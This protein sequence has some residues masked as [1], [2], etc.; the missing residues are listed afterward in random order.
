MAR[1]NVQGVGV[2]PGV[3]AKSLPLHLA[4]SI[5]FTLENHEFGSTNGDCCHSEPTGGHGSLLDEPDSHHTRVLTLSRECQ[6]LATISSSKQNGPLQQS[7][8][9]A[10]PV[11]KAF[12]YRGFPLALSPGAVAVRIH[13]TRTVRLHWHRTVTEVRTL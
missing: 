9:Q 12:L 7:G 13:G 1:S 3:R 4:S 11:Q 10:G 2:G 5:G 6:A 8:H